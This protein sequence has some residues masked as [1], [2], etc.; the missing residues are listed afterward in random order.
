MERSGEVEDGEV[1]GGTREIEGLG[2]SQGPRRGAGRGRRLH[3]CFGYRKSLREQELVN[4]GGHVCCNGVD[5]D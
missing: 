4:G 1:G 3:D 5:A 2:L